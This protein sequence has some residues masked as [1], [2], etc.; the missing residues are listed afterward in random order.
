MSTTQE[1]AAADRRYRLAKGG[2][3]T[4]DN[5]FASSR[6]L[7]SALDKIVPDHWSFMVG[8]IAMDSLII[9]ILT[10]IYLAVFYIP[11]STDV[12]YAPTSGHVYAP[13]VGQHMSEAYQSV[14][15]ISFD[16][17]FGLIMRQAHHWAAL[18]FLAAVMFHMGRIFFTGA[19]RKPREINWIIGLILWQIVSLEGF[20]GYSLPDD[21]LSGTGIRVIYSIV[22]S[23]PFIGTWLVYALW[24]GR[25][26][27]STFIPRLFVIH[28]FLFPL[29]IIGLLTAHL[30]ILW[31]QKH[32]DFPG[33]GKTETNIRGS[34][35]WPQYAMKAG[36]LMMLVGAVTFGL[37][38][39]V[40]INPVWLYGPYTPFTVSAGSQP[41]WY[42]GWLDGSVRLW[43]HW[44]FR[45]FGHEIANPFFPGL[46]IPGILFGLMFAWPWIDKK[47]YN[48]YGAHNLLDRP[49]DKPFRTALGVATVIFFTD[50]TLACG[51]DL[52]ANNLHVPFE[53][54]IEWL[55]YGVF[56]GPIVGFLIAYRACLSLQRVGS[57][58]IQRPVGGIIYRT[59]TGAY[60]TVGDVHHGNGHGEP[61]GDE[62]H[63][64][65]ARSGSGVESG[66]A[67]EQAPRQAPETV[68]GD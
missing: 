6:W 39:F 58:P 45:S 11:S 54:L 21:L 64:A 48:D 5:R 23:I 13:L 10:G 55:Q 20:T 66:S 28:E 31:H 18:I 12:V 3:D 40:Q 37:A 9:L 26:P 15:N 51:T 50:L 43:P 47:I 33:P 1:R 49:R 35:V 57:H 16:V 46:L 19:F 25:F 59:A 2:F 4:V 36:G 62:G 7:V 17:R 67:A 61:A 38:G 56:V 24:G 22:Q 42:L 32:T 14:I 30:M 60:H 68:A 44:E 65:V 63:A 27:G 52:L 29:I 41:D 53:R 34:R 8:E